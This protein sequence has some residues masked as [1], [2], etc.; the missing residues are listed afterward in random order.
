MLGLQQEGAFGGERNLARAELECEPAFKKANPSRVS[1]FR[2][3]C[4]FNAPKQS[5]VCTQMM[6]PIIISLCCEY[7]SSKYPL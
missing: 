4:G 3:L 6:S 5:T 1:T 2:A 7:Q